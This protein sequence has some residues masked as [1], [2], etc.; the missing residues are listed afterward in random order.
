MVTSFLERQ[1]RGMVKNEK[2]AHF[3]ES[4]EFVQNTEHTIR[5]KNTNQTKIINE[6]GAKT[7]R[8]R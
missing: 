4:T 7:A 8:H 1:N 6:G 3:I 5:P 2:A